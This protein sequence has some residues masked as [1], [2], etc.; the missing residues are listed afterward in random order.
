MLLPEILRRSRHIAVA[1]LLALPLTGCI[2]YKHIPVA[3]VADV[4]ASEVLR[5]RTA[6]VVPPSRLALVA[7]MPGNRKLQAHMADSTATW[8]APPSGTVDYQVEYNHSQKMTNGGQ[9]GAT[10]VLYLF[11]GGGLPAVGTMSEQSEMIIR[12]NGEEVFRDT[13]VTRVRRALTV[14]TPFALFAGSMGTG[15]PTQAV[16]HLV[17]GHRAAL[18][19]RIDEEQTDFSTA[20]A[21]GTAAAFGQYLDSHPRSFFRG[22][23]LR[24]LSAIAARSGNPLA[25]H[26][27]YAARYPDYAR[28]LDIGDALWFVG[29]P[30]MQV[31]DIAPAIRR[32][33]GAELLAAQIRA[34]RQP[35]KLFND[36]E[37]A[38]LKRRGVPDLVAAAMMDVTREVS[39][40]PTAVMEP[41]AGGRA[42]RGGA[43][44]ST[45]AAPAAAGNAATMAPAAPAQ[46][47]GVGAQAAGAAS[48]CAKAYIAKKACEK[49]P[50]PTPFG[51]AIKACI[52][53]VKQTYG[54]AGCPLL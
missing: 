7:S 45:M 12:A 1:F 33:T 14:W 8:F 29:P 54:G 4:P 42:V 11:T 50:D 47:E 46:A 19:R 44:F 9:F 18:S 48:E 53:K 13:Q 30:G 28:Y 10:F 23:A 49:I 25:A 16:D 22:E 38:L 3:P 40:A 17:A 36:D 21:A 35:Y 27:S 5:S 31:M 15:Q 43:L 20:V 2:T 39:V 32:G 41:D 37:L 51:F 6:T 34:A 52:K 24:G 26:K